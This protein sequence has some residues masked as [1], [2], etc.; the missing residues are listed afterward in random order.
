MNQKPVDP[1]ELVGEPPAGDANRE[2]FT[3]DHQPSDQTGDERETVNRESHAN[4]AGPEGLAGDMGLSSERTDGF[5]GVEGTGSAAS[6]QG[7]TDGETP[8]T[9][10]EAT[11]GPEP[12]DHPPDDDEA[13]DKPDETSPATHVDRT[14][15]EVQPDPV[16]HKH[17]F[18]P[19]RNPG[20]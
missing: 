15:G 19:G 4:A 3:S 6:A 9:R 5:E 10:V 18:D 14:V 13:P 2:G 17:E 8:T 12:A 16:A 1:Y 20:H 7:S 11:K